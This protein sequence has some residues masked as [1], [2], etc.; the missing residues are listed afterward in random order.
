[1]KLFTKRAI[2]AVALL[3]FILTSI[4]WSSRA[5]GAPAAPASDAVRGKALFMQYGCYTCHGTVGQGNFEAGPSIAPH[6]LPLVAIIHQ[7]R[8]PANQ[9]PAYAANIVSDQDAA[10][11]YAYLNSIPAGKPA[12]DIPIL[13]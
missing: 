10:A 8:T 1:M 3:A 5:A 6:P 4:L 11:I 12:A 9:M 13:K 7:L 2:P